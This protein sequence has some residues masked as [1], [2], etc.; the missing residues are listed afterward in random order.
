MKTLYLILCLLGA[1]VPL[2]LFLP[3]LGQ[4]G[5][6]FPLLIQQ[7]WAS[8]VAAFAWADVAMSALAL[9]AFMA[10]DNKRHPVRQRGWVVAAL[11]LIGPSLALPRY[12][13]LREPVGSHGVDGGKGS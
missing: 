13:L 10:H 12:L 5:L 6:N 3:W 1:S 9:L 2:G 11:C 7:V 8:P 4:H